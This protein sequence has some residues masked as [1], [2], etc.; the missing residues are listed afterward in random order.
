MQSDDYKLIVAYKITNTFYNDLN[1][2]H[3]NKKDL[4]EHFLLD[5]K[6]ALR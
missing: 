6:Y 3:I 1:I 4:F 5:L 2:A